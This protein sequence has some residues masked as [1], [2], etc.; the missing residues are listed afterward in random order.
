[1]YFS[2]YFVWFTIHLDILSVMHWGQERGGG[3]GVVID[4]LYSKKQFPPC[5]TQFL[6]QLGKFTTIL[7]KSFSE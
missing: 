6:V 4:S 7:Q 5:W 3:A 1:M 2:F